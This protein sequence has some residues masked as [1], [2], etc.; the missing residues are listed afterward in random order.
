MRQDLDTLLE[1][2]EKTLKAKSFTVFRGQSRGLDTRPQVEWDVEARPD[3]HEFLT[4]AESL[5]VRLIVV[6]QSKLDPE[7]IET[8]LERL[9]VAEVPANERREY[10][11]DLER[12]RGYDGFSCSLQLSFDYN[13]LTYLYELFTPWYTELLDIAEEL[14]A[15]IE[16]HVRQSQQGP[17]GGYYSQN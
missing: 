15:A 7:L 17:I 9:E 3:F 10:Q 1:E 6:Q 8:A 2:V 14:D 16:E 12:L 11:R 13:G 4:V 5:G